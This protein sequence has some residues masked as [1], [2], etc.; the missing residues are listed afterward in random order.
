MGESGVYD[1]ESSFS[2]AAS[3][4]V[5]VD[6]GRPQI[7]GKQGDCNFQHISKKQRLAGKSWSSQALSDLVSAAHQK[8]ADAAAKGAAAAPSGDS[9]HAEDG[10]AKGEGD[11]PDG[12]DDDL[13]GERAAEAALG[14]LAAAGKRGRKAAAS[15]VKGK[16]AKPAPGADGGVGGPAKKAKS[17]SSLVTATAKFQKELAEVL[18]KFKEQKIQ[19]GPLANKLKGLKT[20]HA[21]LLGEIEGRDDEAATTAISASDSLI[22]TIETIGSVLTT[23][24]A[25][26]NL[27]GAVT[28]LKGHVDKQPAL[29]FFAE[30]RALAGDATLKKAT[31]AVYFE[32][33]VKIQCWRA[34]QESAGEP[35]R[36]ALAF[37]NVKFL[38]D[39]SDSECVAMQ[40]TVVSKLM[41]EAM[42]SGS[43]GA[44]SD[45]LIEWMTVLTEPRY[46]DEFGNAALAREL[47]LVAKVV[48]G[49]PSEAD[50]AEL[51]GLTS[52]PGFQFRVSKLGA[53]MV[54]KAQ[55][56]VA[57]TRNLQ[58]FDR[59]WGQL[60]GEVG[61]LAQGERGDGEE[62]LAWLDRILPV[63]SRIMEC[64][65]F[66]ENA[67]ERFWSDKNLG[68]LV[69]KYCELFAS[70]VVPPLAEDASRQCE[71]L[72]ESMLKFIEADA[73]PSDVEAWKSSTRSLGDS[74]L[75]KLK[76]FVVALPK[77]VS[78][79][80]ERRFEAVQAIR[81]APP[82]EKSCEKRGVRLTRD[83]PWSARR[84]FRCETKRNEP[85]GG[86]PVG[87]GRSPFRKNLIQD[88]FP[89]M[90]IPTFWVLG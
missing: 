30:A 27:F 32:L 53:G 58:V 88:P 42:C 12:N 46:Q 54:A 45:C 39:F 16:G 28:K 1:I 4:R 61:I 31:P 63:L 56:D 55:T 69:D 64:R 89:G 84:P 43:H 66:L 29:D 10:G 38:F 2:Q 36:E 65:K 87:K 60:Q 6:D 21:K 80:H 70:Q 40:R 74:A 52:G 25:A 49:Q 85:M 50:L 83:L 5:L 13:F 72:A 79:V 17:S 90:P 7:D 78:L 81:A 26:K 9:V 57:S 33:M 62:F 35:L 15:A 23:Y 67:P 18:Q 48:K 24:A 22:E 59:R 11:G 71:T 51:K 41:M 47:Q 75:F 34:V 73:A 3:K 76:P 37:E 68:E 77:A 86:G 8:K 44:I 82:N 14:C 20:A 19:P